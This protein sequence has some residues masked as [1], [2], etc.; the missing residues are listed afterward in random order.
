MNLRAHAGLLGFIL[1]TL[2]LLPGC[3]S[4]SHSAPPPP[5]QTS[6]YS[7]Y[8]TGMELING[9]PNFYA[10][11]GSL[12]IDQNGK[13]TGGRQDYNDAFGLTSPQPSGDKITG[14][15]LTVDTTG[16]GT[17]TL[18]T[19]NVN[20]GLNG[21]ET[22]GVQFTNTKHGLVV[23]FDGTT[24]S[25]GSIDLQT[26]PSTLNGPYAFTLSGVDP[27][28]Q[29]VVFGGLFS[30]TGT[31]VENGVVD[32]DD[33]GIVSLGVPFTG[34]ISA[35]DAFG[36]GTITNTG[37]AT[38]FNYY[39]IGPK[40]IRII[41]MDT[42]DAVVGSAFAQGAGTF[43]NASLGSSVFGVES[44]SFAF[45]YVAA[46]MFTTV[47]GSGTFQ[48][49][50]D[51]DEEGGVLNG[52]PIAGTYSIGSNGYGGMTIT[53]GDLGDVSAFGIYM[54]DPT[55][56]LNDPNNT[57][58]GLGGGLVADLDSFL[59]GTGVLTPQTDTSTASYAGNYAFGAQ[60]FFGC[61]GVCE[62]DFVGQGSVASGA[63][64]GTGVLS[65]P[66]GG[67]GGGV[68]NDILVSGTATPDALNAGRYTI[69]LA[70][71]AASEI[72]F[73]V[74]IYQASGEQLY[75]INTDLG[76]LFLGPLE[77][78]GSLSGL[79]AAI[80]NAVKPDRKH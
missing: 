27:G 70:I 58:S 62:F 31:N 12:T 15:T 32:V 59:N 76:S 38:T 13:V 63:L 23:H 8:M 16:Q 25:S 9:G 74:V 2:A 22:L 41:D 53:P 75:W 50:G 64:T 73:S 10:V 49:V 18:I 30:V 77:Q 65:D 6:A 80:T 69:P 1:L 61:N 54:T 56:N 42:A 44:N 36:R 14:G 52:A 51:V 29:P 21:T 35:P 3:G 26:L 11:A 4:S 34:T 33:A 60:D 28:Y 55:L 24:A 19:N 71:T 66:F 43:S 57:T 68:A 46:G 47:P 37:I 40:A 79:P 17:L 45:V 20:L 5:S 78:Q 39:I 48:G 72:D 7:F 67:F